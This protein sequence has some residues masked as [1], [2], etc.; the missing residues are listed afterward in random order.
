MVKQF[1]CLLFAAISTCAV[2]SPPHITDKGDNQS[3]SYFPQFG[4]AATFAPGFMK[5]QKRPNFHLHGYG[6]VY[7]DKR[8]SIRGD[9]FILLP[10]ANDEA[11]FDSHYTFSAGP[12]FH[13]T[14]GRAVDPYAGFTVGFTYSQ[15]SHTLMSYSTQPA[16]NPLFMPHAGCRIFA[17]QWFYV[18]AEANYAVG[19][20]F[21]ENHPAVSFSELRIS[22]GLGIQF[23][24]KRTQPAAL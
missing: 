20:H 7:I 12:S 2:A 19:K 1:L 6:F 22:A 24:K 5:N 16:L 3:A 13:F 10:S 18:F 8:V 23:S 4:G 11:I 14:H 9:A 15:L 21:P 17:E